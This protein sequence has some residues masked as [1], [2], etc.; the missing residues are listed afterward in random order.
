MKAI[1]SAFSCFWWRLKVVLG[2]GMQV[3]TDAGNEK[4]GKT[5]VRFAFNVI[6]TDTRE[7]LLPHFPAEEAGNL[8]ITYQNYC[9]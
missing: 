4:G 8:G 1:R 5:N 9:D 6:C 3:S 2:E 7:S